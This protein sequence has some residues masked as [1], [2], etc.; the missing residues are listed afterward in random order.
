[1]MS[2]P[3]TATSTPALLYYEQHATAKEC[4]QDPSDFPANQGT[5]A[6][7]M[8][9]P[10]NNTT[11]C[12]AQNPSFA[13]FPIKDEKT[14]NRE[15]PDVPTI[16]RDDTEQT[17]GWIITP[18]NRSSPTD[19]LSLDPE[20]DPDCSLGNPLEQVSSSPP[21]S[22]VKENPPSPKT[23]LSG[24]SDNGWFATGE[25]KQEEDVISSGMLRTT[26]GKLILVETVRA[27]M[28]KTTVCENWTTC[29]RK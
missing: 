6:A 23:S 12:A 14:K 22:D 10:T 1:M 3:N 26:A 8:H 19:Q 18:S 28:M 21:P 15:A 9:H 4:Q 16:K 17:D 7:D 24:V 2:A 11:H 27:V 25:W 13:P 5:N 20:E 29:I